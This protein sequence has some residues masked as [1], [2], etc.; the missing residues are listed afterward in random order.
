MG[1]DLETKIVIRAK[2]FASK[3]VSRILGVGNRLRSMVFNL[4][5]AFVALAGAAGLGLVIKSL[6]STASSFENLGIQ[7][8]A[9]QG[10]ALAGQQALA[11]VKDF[12][13]TTPLSLE[14]VTQAFVRAKALGLDVMNGTMQSLVD[15]SSKLGGGQD[16][17]MGVV[18]AVGQAWTKQKF[19][20]E[21][22]NQLIERGV[23]VWELLSKAMDKSKKELDALAVKGKL[24]RDAISK[25][26]KAM[27]ASAV[28]A[29]KKNMETLTGIMSNFG[30]QI[31]QAKDEF[32]SAK[33]GLVD[34]AKAGLS[35]VTEEIEKLRDT[36][37]LKNLGTDL[38]RNIISG[39]RSGIEA[40]IEFLNWLDELQGS[41]KLA[42]ANMLQFNLFLARI[43]DT[44]GTTTGQAAKF[45]DE[46]NRLESEAGKF[47][48]SARERSS[49]LEDVGKFFDKLENR[50]EEFRAKTAG[51]NALAASLQ[52]G[53]PAQ[54]PLSDASL[55][56]E[57]AGF[58]IAAEAQKQFLAD[59]LARQQEAMGEAFLIR[60]L[61]Q[62]NI[63]AA[64]ASHQERLG[65]MFLDAA[66]LRISVAENELAEIQR[67]ENLKT[68]A[69]SDSFSA[70]ANFANALFIFTGQK[71]KALF[72]A[73]KVFNI[74][75]AITDTYAGANK[76]LASVPYPYN[77]AAAASVVGLGLANVARISATSF[78]STGGGGGGGTPLIGADRTGPRTDF[79][80]NQNQQP[81][82][83]VT[84]NVHA[85]DPA[86]VDWHEVWANAS[87]A[88]GDELKRSNGNF[89]DVQIAFERT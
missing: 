22:A 14:G 66:Q 58:G 72:N 33:G 86:S 39:L 24:G 12:A 62:Q 78:G 70:A 74:A 37:G 29:A 61:D 82:P 32:A 48:L 1:N 21:E 31:S 87:A 4:R 65:Q 19:Q 89:G 77:I 73:V 75:Q 67:I 27:G 44:L 36:G 34:F 79:N 9:L 52:S 5:T 54:L 40:V 23:P 30:D 38:G 8:E 15:I 18:L 42:S 25:L 51:K 47:F 64:E 81:A 88:L 7:L 80:G 41:V 6:L 11:W 2:D 28:G 53:I 60:A 69:R 43:S 17:L 76:A 50:L 49:A 57:D 10:S 20:A 3:T 83:Q 59:K 26:I 84:L 68:Q 35:L 13:K 45:A 55:L 71:N 85:L 16:R 56:Q 46:I 63:E